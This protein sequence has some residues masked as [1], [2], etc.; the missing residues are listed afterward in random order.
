VTRRDSYCL[1]ARQAL[2]AESL[3]GWPLHC[4]VVHGVGC[5]PQWATPKGLGFTPNLN[6]KP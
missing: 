1:R 5:V 6:L 4:A 2:Q 3:G